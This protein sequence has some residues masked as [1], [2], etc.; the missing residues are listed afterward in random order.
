MRMV[1]FNPQP[2]IFGH[3]DECFWWGPKD[4]RVTIHE[5]R[6]TLRTYQEPSAHSEKTPQPTLSE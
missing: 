3:L 1:A 5:D 4:G 2:S 6:A